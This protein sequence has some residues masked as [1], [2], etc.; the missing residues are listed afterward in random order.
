MKRLKYL[1][2]S[3]L[4]FLIGV[5]PLAGCVNVVDGPTTYYV[6]NDYFTYL[7]FSKQNKNGE[8]S[9]SVQSVCDMS[10]CEYT[11]GVTVYDAD[12]VAL[13]TESKTVQATVNE[14]VAFTCQFTATA[15]IYD[16]ADR[17]EV[18]YSGFSYENPASVTPSAFV[19]T[20][21]VTFMNGATQ[22][23]QVS[24]KHGA[25][26]ATP[27]NPTKNNY[28]FRAWYADS[29]FTKPYDFA[30]GITKD[31]TLYAGFDLDAW[32]ITNTVTTDV[33]HAVVTVYN[34]SY[35]NF[36]GQETDVSTSQGSGVIIKQDGN[37]FYLLTNCHV[38]MIKEG[39]SKQKFV[40]EDYQGKQYTGH[41]YHNS[42]VGKDAVDAGY[43]L[44]CLYFESE[45]ENL[46]A[47]A[48][49]DGDPKVGDDVIALGTP[50]G[51]ANAITY[52]KITRYGT[53]S[54]KTEEYL[55]NVDFE[56]AKHNAYITHGSS[57]GA[58]LNSDLKLTAINFA[59]NE[60]QKVYC[61]V[62]LSKITE[63]LTKYGWF[64]V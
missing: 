11:I 27:A 1:L 23:K 10:L 42:T 29:A 37:T 5:L 32:S 35:N 39:C 9:L 3:I 55:S 28:I 62:Q 52:G 18:S 57:G 30:Q 25:T 38:A 46:K 43:D 13:K 17:V 14:S 53:V 15:E 7:D 44:A 36:L 59:G 63:F 54:V 8:L 6:S 47:L 34:K 41:Y 22:V 20:H 4:L 33:I 12:D 19:A 60:E 61:A 58:L 24:I 2:L 31:L 49:A 40:V 50:Y 48:F 26:V 45:S 51:Q 16:G 21:T 64:T 56:V